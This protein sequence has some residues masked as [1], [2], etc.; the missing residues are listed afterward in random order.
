MDILMI[1]PTV[2]PLSAIS[3]IVG[4]METYVFS[5]AE[6]LANIKNNYVT[7]FT[8]S[9]KHGVEI[10]AGNH[11]KILG[12]KSLSVFPFSTQNPL[13]LDMKPLLSGGYD[14]I[15][16]HQLYTLSSILSCS[17]AKMQS[18]PSILTDHGGGSKPLVA[19]GNLPAKFPSAFATVSA[20]SS[21]C[22]NRL[23]PN[24]KT[25]VVYGGVDINRFKPLQNFDW[26][27]KKF[28]IEDSFVILYVGKVAPYK[29][30]EV[31]IKALHY[32][33][34]T[35]K[36]LIV[37]PCLDKAYLN[38]LQTIIAVLPGRVH[39]T[40][41]IADDELPLYYNICDVFVMASIH[42]DYIGK[43]HRFPEL[44]GL[45]KL[46]AMACNKPI[47]VSAVGGLPEGVVEGENGFVF[48]E[49]DEKQLAQSIE[50][51][52][53][54]DKLKKQMGNVAYREVHENFTWTCVANRV[55]AA[56]RKLL[57]EF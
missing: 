11:L 36:L 51:L 15:H 41:S 8:G 47:V 34:K 26:L 33:P 48:A 17:L 31:L 16:A 45:S 18:I 14:I 54:D 24:A 6:A 46:E 57:D 12:T 23:V 30:V 10:Y 20:Y 13:Y 40:G 1:S 55:M 42:T 2:P 50:V 19:L 43:Y 25:F 35:A 32:L 4:G 28:D 9:K 56:Y 22:I 38:Y 39:F 7:V 52:L 29:G 27:R 53:N 49:G 44:L 5:L 37:G 3:G 21:I